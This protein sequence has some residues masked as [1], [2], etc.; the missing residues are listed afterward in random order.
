MYEIAACI[1]KV[2]GYS[3]ILPEVHREKDTTRH[4][5]LEA[6]C[7]M[8]A[9]SQCRKSRV[10]TDSTWLHYASAITEQRNVG[11]CW[12]KT[13]TGFKLCAKT[14]NKQATTYSN[15]HATGCA[16]GRNEGASKTG[17]FED[18]TPLESENLKI[19]IIE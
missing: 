9:W 16:N 10:Q 19:S 1:I 15:M 14:R 17:N 12:L 7:N 11:S 6:M 18:E 3:E 5:T 4:K 2:W 8:S 13:L